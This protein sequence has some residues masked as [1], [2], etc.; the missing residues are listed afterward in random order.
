[1]RQTLEVDIRVNDALR[2][3]L[4]LS[5]QRTVLRD[6]VVTRENKVLRGLAEAGVRIQVRAQQSSGLLT[7]KVAA[8]ARLADDLIRSR[9]VDD[10]VRAHLRQRSGRRVRHPQILANFYAEGEQRLLIALKNAVGHNRYIARLTGCIS[11]RYALD[12]TQRICRYEMALLV[13]L[14]VVRKMGFRHER[15]HVTGIDDSG[16]IIQLAAHAQRQT[17]YDDSRKLCGLAADGT[18]RLHRA[19]EQRFLQEQV[20]AGIAGQAQLGECDELRAFGSGLLRQLY[21]LRGIICTV[22]DV[23]IRRCRGNFDKSISHR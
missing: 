13:E 23:Q 8:V 14:G 2:E 19:L 9:Q 16:H 12:R 1:M 6:E 21:D 7:N 5:Q 10:N 20:A 22:R 17:D 18:E 4:A 11:K 15:Q 3:H